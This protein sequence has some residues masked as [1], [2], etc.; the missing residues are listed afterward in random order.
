MEFQ[1]LKYIYIPSGNKQASTL[2]LL[3]GTGGDENDL[4]P[5]AKDFGTDFNILSVRGNVSENGM[6]RFF[7]RLG[8]GIFDEQDLHFRT[9]EL[10]SFIKSIS[11]EK[12]FDLTKIIALGYSNGANIAGAILT[13]YPHFLGGAILY[14]PMQPFKSLLPFR[15]DTNT[16][17]FISSGSH[18]NTVNPDDTTR[19]VAILKDSGFE[20]SHFVIKAMHGLTAED[21]SL[22]NQWLNTNGNA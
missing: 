9:D 13:K 18:D 11:E 12:G 6:P 16:P 19:Y 1:P 10:V 2:L 7:E 21:L 20:V 5:I 17:I 15:N 8:M 3:H 4:I 22:T 14:R